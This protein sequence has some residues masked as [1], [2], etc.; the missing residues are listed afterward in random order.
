MP[1]GNPPSHLTQSRI[2]YTWLGRGNQQLLFAIKCGNE[3]DSKWQLL[4]DAHGV[5]K[6]FQETLTFL[7]YIT[8]IW[9]SGDLT[10]YRRI[11]GGPGN[12]LRTAIV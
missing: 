12:A 11:E 10:I 4:L 3:H 9:S 1:F 5:P 2:I 6:V 7:V 8:G